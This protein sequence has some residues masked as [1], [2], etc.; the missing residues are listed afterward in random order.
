[1]PGQA[2]TSR[3]RAGK[4]TRVRRRLATLRD[5]LQA[6]LPEDS[7]RPPPPPRPPPPRG[8]RA[9]T[10]TPASSGKA[11]LRRAPTRPRF[12]GPASIILGPITNT[13]LAAPTS[14]TCTGPPPTSGP[15]THGRSPGLEIPHPGEGCTPNPPAAAHESAQPAP[16]HAAPGRVPEGKQPEPSHPRVPLDRLQLQ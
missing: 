14:R 11:R 15:P 13:W 7:G 5:A 16:V 3:P 10:L 4:R 6:G 9:S 1:M 8:V 12:L 2:K